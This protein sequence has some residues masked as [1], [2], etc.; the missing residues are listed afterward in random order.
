MTASSYRVMSKEVENHIL[1]TMQFLGTHVCINNPY[2]QS[3]EI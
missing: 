3:S 1:N 2:L